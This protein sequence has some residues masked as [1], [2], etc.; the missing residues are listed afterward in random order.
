VTSLSPKT[1]DLC[2]EH[3]SLASCELQLRSWGRRTAFHG[4]IRT[5]R[6]FEDNVLL[7][8]AL[9]RPS[10]GEVLVVDGGG[11]LRTALIGDVIATL[12]MRNGWAGVVIHGAVRDVLALERLEFGVKALGSNPRKSAKSGR[13]E[14]DVPV[15]FGGI[16]FTPGHELYSDEDGIVVS[17]H[18]L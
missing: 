3:P 6:C 5:V 10:A 15:T 8:A 13:G 2:D 18:A 12:G 7:K 14:P 4:P 17:E 16:T 11:S 1:A 9:S